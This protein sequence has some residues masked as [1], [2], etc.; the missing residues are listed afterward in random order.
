MSSSFLSFRTDKSV[1][2]AHR[3]THEN[4]TKKTNCNKTSPARQMTHFYL[5][6]LIYWTM[7]LHLPSDFFHP[8]TLWAPQLP[9]LF[10]ESHF[11]VGYQLRRRRSWSYSWPWTHWLNRRRRPWTLIEPYF[12]PAV[13]LSVGW[14]WNYRT[15]NLTGVGCWVWV[16]WQRRE[17]DFVAVPDCDNLMVLQ[18]KFRENIYLFRPYRL[19][20]SQSGAVLLPAWWN[21][22]LS[23]H[24]CSQP[25]QRSIPAEG[26]TRE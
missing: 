4:G 16:W 24:T 3:A 25:E 23:S 15:I 9:L 8:P 5:F 2:P 21:V 26:K 1:T 20:R 17:G 10:I 11:A 13:I 19:A 6:R 14:S 22:V 7:R 12:S 18:W